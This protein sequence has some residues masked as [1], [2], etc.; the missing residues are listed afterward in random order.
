MREIHTHCKKL[1]KT[2]KRIK[3]KTGL[4]YL[5]L[6]SCYLLFQTFFC[7]Y[8]YIELYRKIYI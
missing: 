8:L 1:K 5:L 2:K 7:A 3:L 6:P 4:L